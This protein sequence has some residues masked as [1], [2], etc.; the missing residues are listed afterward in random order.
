MQN[1]VSLSK[2][3]SRTRRASQHPAGG[4]AGADVA[5]LPGGAARRHREPRGRVR[6]AG[7]AGRRPRAHRAAVRQGHR[8]PAGQS[9]ALQCG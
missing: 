5:Q 3:Y 7:A 8:I 6:T 2:L 4:R 1:S 9:T